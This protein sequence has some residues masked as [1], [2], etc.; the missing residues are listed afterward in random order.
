LTA[1]LLI[2]TY[3]TKYFFIVVVVVVAV[4]TGKG[5]L[6]TWDQSFVT[7]LFKHY[8]FPEYLAFNHSQYN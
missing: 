5:R 6:R 8:D 3:F 1:I 4:V 7:V 2:F